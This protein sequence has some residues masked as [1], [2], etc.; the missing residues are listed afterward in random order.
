MRQQD[1][2]T[3]ASVSQIGQQ[4]R[5]MESSY[6]EN[7]NNITAS[8]IIENQIQLEHSVIKLKRGGANTSSSGTPASGSR[9]SRATTKGGNNAL[10]IL[11]QDNGPLEDDSLLL[12]CY[13]HLNTTTHH[14]LPQ[15]PVSVPYLPV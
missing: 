7:Q 1:L 15:N 4:L 2:D 13:E 11:T 6:I 9:A 10:L 8:A 14:Y 5:R 12:N 3:S